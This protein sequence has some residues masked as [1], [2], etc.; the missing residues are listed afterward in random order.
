[1]DDMPAATL[2]KSKVGNNSPMDLL[3]AISELQPPQIGGGD[4]IMSNR[5]Y[6]AHAH[7]FSPQQ[8]VKLGPQTLDMKNCTNA[9][10]WKQL[11]P[12]SSKEGLIYSD[13]HIDVSCQI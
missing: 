3:S 8:T 13:D 1:M 11:L 4:E 7:R 6:L 12:Y 9:A 10:S 2:E 5:F